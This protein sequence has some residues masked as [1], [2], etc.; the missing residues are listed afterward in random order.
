MGAADREDDNTSNLKC[1]TSNIDMFAEPVPSLA[2]VHST[3]PGKIH[4]RLI[5]IL[6]YG[7][8]MFNCSGQNDPKVSRIAF[9]LLSFT[10]MLFNHCKIPIRRFSSTWGNMKK[11]DLSP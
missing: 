6:G 10:L 5:F 11:T 7:I 1:L 9:Y 3:S 4:S 2:Y 8:R